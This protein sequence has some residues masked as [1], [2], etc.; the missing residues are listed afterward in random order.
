MKHIILFLIIILA[1]CHTDNPNDNQTASIRSYADT[2]YFYYPDLSVVS[3]ATATKQWQYENIDTVILDTLQN[4]FPVTGQEGYLVTIKTK[5]GNVYSHIVK[6][7]ERKRPLDYT[8]IE[9]DGNEIYLGK[10]TK[11]SK[12]F[13][14]HQYSDGTYDNSTMCR[15]GNLLSGKGSR[16][17]FINR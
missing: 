1:S 9:L 13:I 17:L 11:Q 3:N 2:I 7:I 8:Y 10:C 6:Y 5:V 16:H 4:Y 14:S 12:Y 15:S